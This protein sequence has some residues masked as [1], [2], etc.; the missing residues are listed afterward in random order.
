MSD[1]LKVAVEDPLA[2]PAGTG[3][4]GVAK[5]EKR[6]KVEVGFDRTDEQVLQF[7][8]DKGIELVW[9]EEGFRELSETV[10]RQLSHDN[11]KNY[12]KAQFKA[13]EKAKKATVEISNPVNPLGMNSDFRLKIRE[14]KGW[15]QC[16]KSPGLELD[17]ALAGPYRQIRKQKE[18]GAKDKYGEAVLE[19]QEPGYENGEVLK[20]MDENNKVELVA[21][22]CPNELFEKYLEYM[23]EKSRLMY[24]ANKGRFAENVEEL[25]TKLDRDHRMKVIDEGGRF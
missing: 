7:N 10:E 8:L 17:A 20:L 2:K 19:K 11:L 5:Q 3:K 21:V 12:L 9:P 13:K 15:H 4:S 24:N 18:T 22:E 25:N 14:R 1:E 6:Q 16:W 23:A